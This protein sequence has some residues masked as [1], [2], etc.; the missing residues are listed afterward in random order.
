M[1]MLRTAVIRELPIDFDRRRWVVTLRP[2]GLEFRAKR[3]R[4][5]FSISWESVLHRTMEIAAAQAFREKHER[6]LAR[7]SA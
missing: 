2:W 4:T 1:T 6:R 3:T 7:R 5:V